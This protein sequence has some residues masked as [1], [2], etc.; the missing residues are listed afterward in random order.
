[1]TVMEQ[2]RATEKDFMKTTVRDV[3]T[4]APTTKPAFREP[5]YLR[6]HW[7]NR[8]V[9]LVAF[10]S[11]SLS[12]N[13]AYY[14]PLNVYRYGDKFFVPYTISTIVVGYPLHVLQVSMG[15]YSQRGIV[16][17]W[18]S[19]PLVGGIGFAMLIACVIM[20]MYYNIFA[21]Y[22]LIYFAHCFNR[23]LPWSRCTN[24]SSDGEICH[25]RIW[26]AV[27]N[28]T[29]PAKHYFYNHILNTPQKY[30]PEVWELGSV[31]W[32]L[33]LAMFFSWF[34]I[35]IAT[36]RSARN[37]DRG[38]ELAYKGIWNV[39]YLN[40]EMWTVAA[41]QVALELGLCHG[42]PLVYGSYCHF[43]TVMCDFDG[44]PWDLLHSSFGIIYIIYSDIF[45]PLKGSNLWCMVFFFMLFCIIIGTQIAIT[46]AIMTVL[47][48]NFIKLSE[49][50]SCFIMNASSLGG[51]IYYKKYVTTAWFYGLHIVFS[52][53]RVLEVHQILGGSTVMR[54]KEKKDTLQKITTL[55]TFGGGN[56]TIS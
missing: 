1:E 7:R 30:P 12:L 28:G 50:R 13:N 37:S 24:I 3:E 43:R 9:Y 5:E 47:Y 4:T 32:W 8:L 19:A 31:K 45:A 48:D 41:M 39:N 6:L 36:L 20:S 25:E 16:W 29:L 2:D 40:I 53:T 23:A 14:F 35:Y 21:A 17:V 49:Y 18:E 27:T 51:V 34:V 11:F 55:H 33:V 42:I 44:F 22:S 46:E 54:A 38:L 26:C 15:Q 10:I 52:K 56:K